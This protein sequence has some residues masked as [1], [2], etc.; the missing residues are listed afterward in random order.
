MKIIMTAC[1]CL[2]VM[3]FGKPVIQHLLA[4]RKRVKTV[5]IDGNW[6]SSLITNL[7]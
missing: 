1:I 5:T 4:K 3:L 7:M 2:P 6:P